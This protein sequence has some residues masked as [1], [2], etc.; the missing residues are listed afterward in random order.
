MTMRQNRVVETIIK[1][2]KI[3]ED[4]IKKNNTLNL[5]KFKELKEIRLEEYAKLR[6]DLC[7]CVKIE[8]DEPQQSF[9]DYVLL[10]LQFISEETHT[11]SEEN[12]NRNEQNEN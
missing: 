9:G 4:F 6:L 11:N 10:N 2:R 7:F 8:K 12:I 1:H 5:D 3:K